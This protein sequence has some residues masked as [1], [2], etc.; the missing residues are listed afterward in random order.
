MP[1]SARRER[2]SSLTDS[3]TAPIPP[4]RHRDNT[5]PIRSLRATGS[6][7]PSR[8]SER[9]AS[10]CLEYRSAESHVRPPSTPRSSFPPVASKPLFLGSIAFVALSIWVTDLHPIVGWVGAAFFALGVPASIFMLLPNNMYL[11]LTPQGFEMHSPLRATFIRW[12]QVE[13]FELCSIWGA[14]VIA[15][16]HS[17][18]YS[19]Q[20]KFRAVA[21]FL[22][23][24]ECAIPNNY[25]ASRVERGAHPWS[26]VRIRGPE[27]QLAR[28][29]TTF[30]S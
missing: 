19:E 1:S 24:V 26:A 21:S 11:R 2:A 20:K 10:S 23:G 25:R 9:A 6:P 5:S 7:S 3:I 18:L 22:A 4:S 27:E 17:A 14:P 16:V 12:S 15:I 30:I 28:E 13:R 8:E 29:A